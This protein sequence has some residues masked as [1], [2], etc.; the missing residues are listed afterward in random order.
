MIAKPLVHL[1]NEEA[2]P[3]YLGSLCFKA[4]TIL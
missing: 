2:N 4:S 1:K 3:S